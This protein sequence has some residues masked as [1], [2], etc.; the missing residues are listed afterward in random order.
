VETV[1]SFLKASIKAGELMSRETASKVG[2]AE[3]KPEPD[4]PAA[5]KD[6]DDIVRSGEHVIKVLVG[7][8]LKSEIESM[9]L[10]DAAL[11]R[12]YQKNDIPIPA[13]DSIKV[14]ELP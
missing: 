7:P 6:T 1:A 14:P 9:R 13:R 11:E 5:Q 10:M 12:F 4:I 8:P 3:M 2:G